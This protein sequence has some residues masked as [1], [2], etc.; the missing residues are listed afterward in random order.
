[1]RIIFFTAKQPITGAKWFLLTA[2]FLCVAPS[3]HAAE[4]FEFASGTTLRGEVVEFKGTNSVVVLGSKD[5]KPYTITIS[6]LSRLSQIHVASLRKPGNA[7][8]WLVDP[9]WQACARTLQ[10]LDAQRAPLVSQRAATENMIQ[11]KKRTK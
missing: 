11:A 8:P 3:L 2:S 5:G 10:T 1:M 4:V 6:D 7:K 9:G